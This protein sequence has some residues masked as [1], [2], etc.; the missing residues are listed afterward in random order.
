MLSIKVDTVQL[1]SEALFV[2]SIPLIFNTAISLLRLFV[3]RTYEYLHRT[4]TTSS[5]VLTHGYV[6]GAWR[7]LVCC[8]I[9][10]EFRRTVDGNHVGVIVAG[11]ASF[12]IIRL[13]GLDIVGNG[14]LTF[15]HGGSFVT[16][17]FR[18]LRLCHGGGV[19]EDRP[20]V[21]VLMLRKRTGGDV[22]C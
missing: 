11:A 16:L 2:G 15:A 13:D 6:E 19:Y 4:G 7:R 12:P 22:L 18:T 8:E 21:E 17:G 3:I 9:D 20:F 10:G 5:S 14:P 1:I